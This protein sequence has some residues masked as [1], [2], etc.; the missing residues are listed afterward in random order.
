MAWIL[1]LGFIAF[2]L[3]RVPITMAIGLAVL[4]SIVFAGFGDTL[5]IIPVQVLQGVNNP[6]LL[7]IPFFVLAGNL[8][9]A[10]GMT[11]RIFNFAGCLVGHFRAGLAQVNVIAS[12]IFAGVSGAA[13]ADIAGLGAV[14][15]KAMRDRGYPAEFAAALTVAAAVIG[16]IIPPSI[17]LVI[18]AY[19][20]GTSVAR[21]FLGGIIP[22]LL[23]VVAL[24]LFNRWAATRYNFPRE[25]RAT[26]KQ[27]ARSA[28]DGIAA[29][30]APAIIL[31]AIVTGFT[32]ATE[33]GVLACAYTLLL[34]LLYRTLSAKALWT[35]MT[36]TML[37]T[38][39]IMIIIGFSH[40]MGWLLAIEMIPQMLA[41]G[42]LL[43]TDSRP[44]FLGL[45]LIFLLLIGCVVEGVPAKLILVP[46]LLP[47]I[48]QFGVDRVHFGLIIQLAL[49]IGI[50]T[51]PMGIGLYIISEVGKV[52]FEKVTIAILPMLVPL[53]VV[54][55]LI[56][57]IPQ[58][59]L[60][61]PNLIMGPG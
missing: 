7:A 21:L 52:S 29:L 5:Y 17:G 35:A 22:G 26:L 57:Y 42:I 33:A 30:I 53:I 48:D 23:I 12:M 58:L 44:V 19:L 43:L 36:D 1:F 40:V 38:S 54:L 32:T 28:I 18:Y 2:I 41:S 34:G 27:T 15:V 61:L 24:M 10:V 3:L 31:F 39:V 37:I 47:L 55:I 6:A 13:V 56:T 46:M 50:A 51:P 59:T 45:L 4:A 20:S 25:E 14:E 60:F 8:M 16:P 49:L 9:N 11:D